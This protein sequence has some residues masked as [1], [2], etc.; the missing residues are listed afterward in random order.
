MVEGQVNDFTISEAGKLCPGNRCETT[1]EVLEAME[2]LR[3]GVAPGSWSLGP[4]APNPVMPT[5]NVVF[6][7]LE[8][9][10][11]AIQYHID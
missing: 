4:M 6:T 3:T 9:Y 10:I 8:H 7:D 11:E 1:R 5:F 2:N